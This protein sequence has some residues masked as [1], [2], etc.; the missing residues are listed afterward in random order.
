MTYQKLELDDDPK[1]AL[2][3]IRAASS[4]RPVLIFKKSPI[5]PVSH[6]AEFEFDR[7]LESLSDADDVSVGGIDVIAR[8][9]LARGLTAELGVQ[10]E[11][12]QALWFANGELV[13]HDSHGALTRERFAELLA[14]DA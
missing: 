10:H 2:A 9:P 3:A 11:S 14:G 6:R 13:W 1:V 5:C 7:W 12:P 8:K 4:E